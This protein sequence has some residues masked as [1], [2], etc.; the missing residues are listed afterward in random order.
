MIATRKT[1]ALYTIILFACITLLSNSFALAASSHKAGVSN[2]TKLQIYVKSYQYDHKLPLNAEIKKIGVMGAFTL[3][4]VFYDSLNG[5]RVPGQIYI[6]TKGNAPYPCVIVQHGYGDSKNFGGLI[7]NV[8]APKGYAVMAIDIEYHGERKETGKDVISTDVKDDVRSLHQ[9]VVDQMRMIDYLASRGDIDMSRIGYVGVSLGSFLGSI[10]S[11][12]DP[13][14][15]STILIVGGGDWN[16]M[17]HTSQV[18]PFAVIQDFCGHDDKKIKAF[19]DQMDVIDPLNYIGLVS[20]RKLLMLN[21]LN[22]K[23]VP[24]ANAEELYSA[25][26]DPKEIQWFTCPGDIG[27]I[28]P[29][30]KITVIVR[31]WLDANML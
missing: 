6:P 17:I 24:K 4:H 23:Y 11:G 20:P 13:R 15:K 21:C 1:R 27:H 7:A 10:L 28:P 8:L 25:A 3:Y 29:I 26:K 30:D 2:E 19:S 9:T 18:P 12:V 16:K 22:D 14:V 5:E 31:K